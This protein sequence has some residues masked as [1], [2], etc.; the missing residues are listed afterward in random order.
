MSRDNV[1]T[2]ERGA[3]WYNGRTPD[4]NNLEG[5]ELE[6]QVKVFEDVNWADVGVKSTRSARKV[7]C[8]L[9]RNLSGITLFG[10]RL[11]TLDPTTRR[12]TGFADTLAEECFPL[13][14]FLPAGGLVNGDMGWVV[15]SGPAIVKTG[16]NGADFITAAIA[17]GDLLVA[18]TTA[19]ASTAAGTTGSAGRLAGVSLTALTTTA[20]GL[21]VI[22]HAVNNI[23]KAMT[24][25]TSGETNADLLVDVGRPRNMW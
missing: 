20:Q 1:S 10:K 24:A 22:N 2:P 17:A 15:I 21:A 3:S 4:L 6:G 14:E 23:G 16:M 12:I 9:V 13:D 19:G 25:R 7:V 5:V 8:M 11:V 18:T